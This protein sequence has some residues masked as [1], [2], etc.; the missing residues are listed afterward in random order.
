M[1]IWA[2]WCRTREWSPTRGGS[3]WPT[4]SG[5]SSSR[6]VPRRIS[7]LGWVSSTYDCWSWSLP[8]LL[9]AETLRSV[10]GGRHCTTRKFFIRTNITIEKQGLARKCLQSLLTCRL[11]Y[12]GCTTAGQHVLEEKNFETC[13]SSKTHTNLQTCRKY[14]TTKACHRVGGK[15]KVLSRAGNTRKDWNKADIYGI[16]L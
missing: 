9:I 5:W 2:G 13:T 1:E 10:E 14:C 11:N 15:R 16:S 12:K 4:A 8:S 7:T 3:T 6:L